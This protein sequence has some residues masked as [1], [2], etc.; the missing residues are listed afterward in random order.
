MNSLFG[1]SKSKNRKAGAGNL[2]DRIGSPTPL[3]PIKING[4][5]ID[6][7]A[8]PQDGRQ[9]PGVPQAPQLLPAL[10]EE[11][12]PYHQ[13]HSQTTPPPPPPPPQP[14]P[15]PRPS[16]SGSNPPASEFDIGE[17]FRGT[18]DSSSNGQPARET[19]RRNQEA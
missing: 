14:L 18:G 8:S 2:K 19:T 3:D 7:K 15:L 17:Y 13:R 5:F 4:S 6:L 9:N 1:R 11:V 12:A 16:H 10:D